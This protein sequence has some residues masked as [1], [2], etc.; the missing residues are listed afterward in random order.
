MCTQPKSSRCLCF[1]LMC[2]RQPSLECAPWMGAN[3]SRRSSYRRASPSLRKI[4]SRIAEVIWPPTR[5]RKKLSSARSCPDQFLGRRSIGSCAPRRMRNFTFNDL[6]TVSRSRRT[7]RLKILLDARQV[8]D[9]P[10]QRQSAGQPG[11]F[12]ADQIDQEGG[13]SVDGDDEVALFL[14]AE[15]HAG[16]DARIAPAEIR[17]FQH[18]K[19]LPQSLDEEPR[20][21][22]LGQIVSFVLYRYLV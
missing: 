22:L 7:H 9:V 11:R 15:H 16:P 14:L 13:V 19:K 2:V 20:R 8:T 4:S 1:I 5:F 21:R 3:P 17:L 6:P 18:G 10:R 12:N